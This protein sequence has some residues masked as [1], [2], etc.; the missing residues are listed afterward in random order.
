MDN[1]KEQ[2]EDWQS[3][4]EGAREQ[5]ERF[6]QEIA[7]LDHNLEAVG[8]TTVEDVEESPAQ[9][10]YGGGRLECQ[11]IERGRVRNGK[12]NMLQKFVLVMMMLME[13]NS[14]IS[15]EQT[16]NLGMWSED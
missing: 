7:L 4:L 16:V 9:L 15:F 13:V 1:I 14:H 3:K 10:A 8:W 6:E 12:A 2:I 11:W 5:V